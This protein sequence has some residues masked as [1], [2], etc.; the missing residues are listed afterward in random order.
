M[1]ASI[2]SSSIR[3]SWQSPL[4]ALQNGD[5]TSYQ[6]TVLELET[7]DVQTFT[8]V[9]TESIHVVNSLHPYYFYNCSVAAY[10][11]GLGPSDYYVVQTL[12]EGEKP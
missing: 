7:G 4:L 3:V 12:S 6:I 11:N 1:A 2:S 10:T 9:P 5:L 8:I